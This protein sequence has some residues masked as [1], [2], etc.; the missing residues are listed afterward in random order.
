[1][2]HDI[3]IKKNEADRSTGLTMVTALSIWGSARPGFESHLYHLRMT[4]AWQAYYCPSYSC[5]DKLPQTWWPNT[6]QKCSLTVLKVRSPKSVP[7][8]EIKMLAGLVLSEGSTSL[9]FPASG[10]HLSSLACGLSLHFKGHHSNLCLH[11]HSTFSSDSDPLA[12]PYEDTCGYSGPS[13]T[14]RDA[15]SISRCLITS[16]LQRP[17]CHIR[18]HS[19]ALGIRTW[20]YWGTIVQPTTASGLISLRPAFLT[21]KKETRSI[22]CLFTSSFTNHTRKSF[23]FTVW[24]ISNAI[25][26]C[27]AI[28]CLETRPATAERENKVRQRCLWVLQS[29]TGSFILLCLG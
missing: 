3:A 16:H 24:T 6:T 21:C 10:G 9:P 8:A 25:K 22:R 7:P 5:Y 29:I 11:H 18:W 2:K 4:C 17:F 20:T 26:R 27:Y 14:S 1:M 23:H 12:S 19:Q 15:L 13:W 28:H